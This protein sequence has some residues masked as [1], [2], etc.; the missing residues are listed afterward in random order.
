MQILLDYDPTSLIDRFFH[1]LGDMG[2]LRFVLAAI[3]VLVW[4]CYPLIYR[5]RFQ[6]AEEAAQDAASVSGARE[7]RKA[8]VAKGRGSPI[9]ALTD[10]RFIMLIVPTLIL[11]ALGIWKISSNAGLVLITAGVLFAFV[12]VLALRT[13]IREHRALAKSPADLIASS[14][15]KLGPSWIVIGVVGIALLSILLL[16]PYTYTDLQWKVFSP[17]QRGTNRMISFLVV[18]PVLLI[19]SFGSYFL[20]KRQTPQPVKMV[21]SGLRL[22][23]LA[24]AF[25]MLCMPF[26]TEESKLE[27]PYR[28]VVLIDDSLSMG[29]VTRG[30]FP[31]LIALKPAASLDLSRL[32]NANPE[33]VLQVVELLGEDISAKT[34]GAANSLRTLRQSLATAS[35]SQA[36][37][38][39]SDIE[40]QEQ[41]VE[42]ALAKLRE[43]GES[44][45]QMLLRMDRVAA[46]NAEE[47]IARAGVREALP[48]QEYEVSDVSLV[49]L[50]LR[51]FVRNLVL[52]R[53]ER[54][55]TKIRV[56]HGEGVNLREWVRIQEATDLLATKIRTN[57]DE[58]SAEAQKT[59][60]SEARMTI[61]R[62]EE[63]KLLAEMEA[64]NKSF[65]EIISTGPVYAAISAN[66][67]LSSDAKEK[68][69]QRLREAIQGAISNLLSTGN[70]RGPTRWDIAC[71]LLQSGNDQTVQSQSGLDLISLSARPASGRLTLLDLLRRSTTRQPDYLP[72]DLAEMA[73]A[74]K[75]SGVNAKPSE[76][77]LNS[78]FTLYTY[79]DTLADFGGNAILRETAVE[80]LDFR[81]P[82]GRTT[83]VYSA[84]NAILSSE[85]AGEISTILIIGDGHDTTPLGA[86]QEATTARNLQTKLASADE[87]PRVLTIAVGN[88][89]PDRVL[90]LKAVSGD[91]EV[92]KGESAEITLSVRA[93]A[94]WKVEVILCKDS[95]NNEIS[96]E[97]LDGRKG[98]RF[99]TIEESPNGD[100][101]TK[102]VRLRFQPTE[103]G[104]YIVKLNRER[105][106]DEDTYENNIGEIRINVIDRRVR[107]LLLDQR[108]RYESRYIIEA[109]ARDRTL[110]FQSFIWDADRPWPQ[111]RSEWPAPKD[112]EPVSWRI[113][114]LQSPFSKTVN[115]G[116]NEAFTMPATSYEDWDKPDVILMGDVSPTKFQQKHLEW[117]SRFVTKDDGGIIWIAGQSHNPQSYAML[118]E[119]DQI[120]PVRVG[121]NYRA[122]QGS[123]RSPRYY[124]MTPQGFSHEIFRF[125]DLAERRRELWGGVDRNEKFRPGQLDGYY[126][127]SPIEGPKDIVSAVLARVARPGE[128]LTMGGE[129][130]SPA[131]IVS[132]EYESG[133]AL[134]VGT[135]ELW[136]TRRYFGD[137]FHYRFWQNAIRWAATNRLK[138]KKEGIDLYTN[139]EAYVLG[140]RV[141]IGCDLLGNPEQYQNLRA[142]QEVEVQEAVARDPGLED[143]VFLLVKW[144]NADFEAGAASRTRESG[145]LTLRNIPGRTD[146]FE[147]FT[148]PNEVGKYELNVIGEPITTKN[149]TI[150]FVRPSTEQTVELRETEVKRQVL[151]ALASPVEVP[152]SD[153]GDSDAESSA[154]VGALS[155]RKVDRYFKWFY[156]IADIQPDLRTKTITGD[157]Q[158]RDLFNLTHLLIALCVLLGLEWAIRKLV[159]LA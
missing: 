153:G 116:T 141:E 133:R 25:T 65:N 118:P 102:E 21:L 111:R 59:S 93:N 52:R 85:M 15:P 67:E 126:W 125:S 35:D 97:A 32:N 80:E 16:A 49:D 51:A 57:K 109:M 45:A 18:I 81:L 64:L 87:R 90:A 154:S 4:A 108:F 37:S 63:G 143:K 6:R 17:L 101:R 8:S 88:P 79:S 152:G 122:E 115:K 40:S 92:V 34:R 107:V 103:S 129:S 75:V 155:A 120:L 119:L 117:L 60:P 39:E 53:T 19:V 33:E 7:D 127:Y 58:L 96:Y 157:M 94:T 24:L 13:L 100:V 149:P 159:R 61:L 83:H 148:L 62:E 70:V 132:R 124:G 137:F 30:E 12:S 2:T 9:L 86:V 84:H 82:S 47:E 151:E 134:F 31:V 98:E 36:D 136:R 104:R 99:F 113:P 147:G 128:E 11:F 76:S 139:E 73:Q 78:P 150:F 135:D 5:R 91:T 50:R 38:L 77:G 123:M 41:V 144:R 138:K 56:L 46:S 23:A 14:A 142:L 105:Q 156:E 10:P 26:V 95:P 69:R 48:A 112:E 28:S 114:P 158:D 43:P 1:P 140:Q 72:T 27:Q 146:R 121:K 130:P 71:E 29:D 3:V 110:E 68:H 145:I 66:A 131:L 106:P 55:S 74:A 44:T 42:L 54:L 89:K 20:I 22:M